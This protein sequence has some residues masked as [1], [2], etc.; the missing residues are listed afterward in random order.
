MTASRKMPAASPSIQISKSIVLVGLMGAGKTNIGKKLALELGCDFC[1]SDQ[2]IETVAGMSISSIFELYGEDKFRDIEAR[3][4]ARLVKGPPQIIS[5]GGGAFMQEETRKIINQDSL[6]VWLKATPATLASRISS[7]N[8]RPLL[9]GKDPVKVLTELSAL[10]SQFYQQAK[11]VV[12]TDGLSLP[13][14]IEKVKSAILDYF[15]QQDGTS[16]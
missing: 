4:I 15:D 2:V 8:S 5:T 12:D 1:D 16:S 7:L 6:S 11:M 14:A 13:A 3:E 9:K 10:R